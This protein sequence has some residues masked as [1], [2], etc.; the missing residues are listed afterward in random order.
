MR[1]A[2][3]FLAGILVTGSSF[4]EA[5]QPSADPILL[6][7]N[8][9]D[10][11]SFVD[12]TRNFQREGDN[13][14]AIIVDAISRAQSRIWIAVF[15]FDLADTAKALIK[16]HNN[17]V[18]VRVVVQQAT[19]EDEFP[20]VLKSR[21]FQQSSDRYYSPALNAMRKAGIVVRD[22]SQG[23][24]GTGLMHH[25]FMVLDESVVVTGS[26]NFTHSD[27]HG[28][29]DNDTTRGNANS[30]LVLG[31]SQLNEVFSQEFSYLWGDGSEDGGLFGAEKPERPARH[32]WVGSTKVSVE[33]SPHPNAKKN[34]RQNQDFSAAPSG[35]L[36]STLRKAQHSIDFALFVFSQ[37]SLVD[38]L[39]DKQSEQNVRI[40]GLIDT[41]F[42]N[43]DYSEALDMWGIE[44][45]NTNC[46]VEKNNRPWSSPLSFVGTP[47][48]SSGDKLHHKYSV[49]DQNTVITGSHNWSES[50]AIKND[51]TI[52][53]IENQKVAE[54]YTEEFHRL[55][56]MRT[57]WGPSQRL[58]KAIKDRKAECGL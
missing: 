21:F 57:Q 47:G 24:G 3:F 53:V 17:G 29:D 4:C 22:N 31:S 58:L 51:E 10:K 41:G 18:D 25:K 55:S 9:N 54:Q 14:E 48:L 36:A 27:F 15:N 32:V 6:Y 28:D 2:Q 33:F 23:E 12:Q 40:R 13:F 43:R 19:E 45:P 26:A 11:N 8:R 38:I 44:M 35:L 50:A 56:R 39:H 42:I 52:L 16:A 37:Q 46:E 34:S 30:L 20:Q 7:F 49:I 1:L 5:L